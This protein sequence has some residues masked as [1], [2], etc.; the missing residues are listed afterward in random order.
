[1]TL[2]RERLLIQKSIDNTCRKYADWLALHVEQREAFTRRI[3]RSCFSLTINECTRD[4]IDRNFQ[5]IKFIQ[6]YSTNCSRVISNLDTG[7]SVASEYLV[8]K[9]VTGEI[10]SENI[11]DLS[12]A[13]LCPSAG[14]LE[15]ETIAKHQDQKIEPKVSR[16]YTCRKCGANKTVPINYQGRAADEADTWAR[17]CIECGFIWR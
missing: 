2:P 4:G 17:N 8:S 12:C 13:E 10:A 5:N 3:E 6:R 14:R 7:G 11:A 15:R 16:K 1:M 9:I